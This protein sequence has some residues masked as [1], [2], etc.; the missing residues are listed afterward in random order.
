MDVQ[1]CRS[2]EA[3]KYALRSPLVSRVEV[4]DDHTTI[5]SYRKAIVHYDFPSYIGFTVL[6]KSKVLMGRLIYD[7]LYDGVFRERR[8]MIAY[9]DTD[10]CIV[11]VTLKENENH[12]YDIIR[13]SDA[14]DNSHFPK[15]HPAYNS[16]RRLTFGIFKDE[17]CVKRIMAGIFLAAKSYCIR[18]ID[19]GSGH[20]TDV[21]RAKGVNRAT[22]AELDFNAYEKVLNESSVMHL[23]MYTILSRKQVLY[24]CEVTKASLSCLN[25]KA[26]FYSKTESW[27][28][29]YWRLVEQDKRCQCAVCGP[30]WVRLQV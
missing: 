27:P 16:E 6:Q 7:K 23:K 1:V 18:T 5:V 28:Y 25:V 8:M 21:L 9:G 10:S 30:Q 11:L 26:Y 24:I 20:M 19:L 2:P 15:D 22:Q 4:I 13:D 12:L 17:L 29:G 14:F 3:L